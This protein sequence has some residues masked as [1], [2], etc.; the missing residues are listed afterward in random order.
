MTQSCSTSTTREHSRFQI[1]F[2]L[3]TTRVTQT[4]ISISK[5][6]ARRLCGSFSIIILKV[7]PLLPLQKLECLLKNFFCR[8]FKF[9]RR[10]NSDN[11]ITG[12]WIL[13]L[14]YL[15]FLLL[16]SWK[17]RESSESPLIII[18]LRPS[19]GSSEQRKNSSLTLLVQ[20]YRQ[21]I[22]YDRIHLP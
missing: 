6:G 7:S 19:P 2:L 20:R 13:R 21:L 1:R 8:I 5:R 16:L 17:R 18:Y 12:L 14:V 10:R 4:P 9:S 3:H 15:L 11:L 22:R